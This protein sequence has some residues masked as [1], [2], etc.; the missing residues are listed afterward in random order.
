[1]CTYPAKE[2]L[3]TVIVSYLMT[4]CNTP[5]NEP[6]LLEGMGMHTRPVTNDFLAQ[7][8]FDQG[9]VLN[10]RI[11]PSCSDNF[12]RNRGAYRPRMRNDLVGIGTR[13]RAIHQCADERGTR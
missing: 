12:I 6:P 2:L 10:I 4:A 9:L 8:Y 1:M 3:I 13:S 7:R 5:A 11:R